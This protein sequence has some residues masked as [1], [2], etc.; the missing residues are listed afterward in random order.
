MA[1][2]LLLLV[3]LLGSQWSNLWSHEEGRQ[4]NQ[5]LFCSAAENQPKLGVGGHHDEIQKR[6]LRRENSRAG[7]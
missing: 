1:S 3:L 2:V 6:L 5:R 4:A 7:F